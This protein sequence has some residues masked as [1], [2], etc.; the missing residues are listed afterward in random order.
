MFPHR[1]SRYMN[2]IL[3]DCIF[4]LKVFA[5]PKNE[6]VYKRLRLFHVQYIL[7]LFNYIHRICSYIEWQYR[8]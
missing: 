4:F 3:N 2:S 8:V 6:R 1:L 5:V 7:L